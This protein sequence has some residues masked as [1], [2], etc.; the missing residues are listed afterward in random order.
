MRASATPGM[1]AIRRSSLRAK[2]WL[3]SAFF[4]VIWTSIGAGAPKFRIWLVMSAGRKEKVV[5]GNVFRSV[6]RSV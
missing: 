1:T 3:A 6:S 4:P 2:A 5:P